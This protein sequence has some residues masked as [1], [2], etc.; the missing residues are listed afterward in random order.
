MIVPCKSCH[1]IFRLDDRL[2]KLNG[3]RVRCSKC[4][5]IFRIFQ[6]EGANRRRYQRVKTRNLISYLSFDKT[7]KLISNGLGIALDVSKG[8]ILL[9]TPYPIETE[10]GRIALAATDGANQLYEVRG[11]LIYS[12]K[13]STGTY[14]S[15]IEFVGI[16]E[17]VTEFITKLIKEYKYR[18]YDLFIAVA[19]KIH[20]LNSESHLRKT[21]P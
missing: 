13:E 1:T 3:A 21:H 18:G 5:E 20:S 14:L 8:G 7:G 19:K 2:L 15:G 6:P 9:E 17:R 12:K 10:T 4:G 16:D 11:K